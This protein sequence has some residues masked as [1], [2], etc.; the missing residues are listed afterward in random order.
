MLGS[1]NAIERSRVNELQNPEDDRPLAAHWRVP[2]LQ[3]TFVY[4]LSSNF[5]GPWLSFLH[6]D[7]VQQRGVGATQDIILKLLDGV[8][9]SDAQPVLVVD[10]LPNRNSV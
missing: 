1:I 3:T 2:C 7:Q 5:M 10:C 4:F 8:P 6:P 9:L